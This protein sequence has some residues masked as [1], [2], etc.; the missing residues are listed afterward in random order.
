MSK[1]AVW[2][3]QVNNTYGRNAFLPYSVGLIQAYC[4]TDPAIAAAYDFCGFCYF[5]ED[6]KTTVARM[7]QC[8]VFGASCYIWNNE[9]T[10][11]LAAEV[12]RRFPRCLVVL[13]GPHVPLRSAQFFHRHPFADV[14]VHYEGEQ[15]FADI[16]RHYHGVGGPNFVDIPGLSIQL[17]DG[18]A[19]KT[20]NRDRIADLSILPS[21]Y[22][23]GVFDEVIKA[24]YDFHASQE[25]NRGCPY[26]CTFCDWGSNTMAKLKQFPI[27]RLVAEI[28][29][30][31]ERKIDLLYNC[32]ANYAIFPR[33]LELTEKM[34]EIKRR[35]GF[36][37]KFRAA[38]AKNSND[39]VFNVARILHKAGMNK[40]VTLSFQSMHD[41]TLQLIKRKNIKIENFADIIGRYRAEGIATYS[42][43]IVGLPGET[44][45]SFADGL[46][47]LVESGQHDSLQ[48]YT[49]EVLPNSEM[50]HPEYQKLHGLETV[51]TPV[52]VFHGTPTTDP[53][54][55]HYELVVAT[56][57]LP[58]DDWMKCQLLSWAFQAFHCLGALQAMAVFIRHQYSIS[59]RSFYER[60]IDLGQQSPETVLGKAVARATEC[61]ENLRAGRDWS[62]V[63]RRFGNIIWPPEEAG[64]LTCV[65]DRDKFY[66]DVTVA[67]S[68]WPELAD[69][70][71]TLL[72]DLSV[73][74]QEIAWA[75]GQEEEYEVRLLHNMHEVLGGYY[76]RMPVAIR[77][78]PVSYVIRPAKTY[79]DLET[80]AREVCWYGRKGGRFRHIDVTNVDNG[81]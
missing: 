38:Y 19:F 68:G 33:D 41:E 10:L 79:R 23:T 9:Y 78:E 25:T 51:K 49:C 80:Y 62:F 24:D 18:E 44:Y 13:G 14:L 8:D 7:D 29:W 12:K 15:A 21:P 30:F 46:N 75:P 73:Y 50:G 43:I 28:E 47:L 37:K 65:A 71:P 56:K 20:P 72:F 57:T 81:L 61:F 53:H 66:Q 5:R 1:R 11:A 3:C 31:A 59:Y 52:L 77:I 67:I 64:F 39:A 34:A 26:S 6:V 70:S 60:I 48:V 63:D 27:E 76:A 16:L 45:D 22:L 58:P 42:E 55:E 54:Q 17:P 36:P 74:Q 32:D 35:T 69:E 40:G 2:L 4:Q